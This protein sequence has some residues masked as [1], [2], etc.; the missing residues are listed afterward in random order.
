MSCD[1]N[2]ASCKDYAN[3]PDPI[4]ENVCNI[5]IDFDY[6]FAMHSSNVYQDNQYYHEEVVF[7]RNENI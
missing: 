3:K 4:G 1:R 6:A 5:F 2:I 7:T